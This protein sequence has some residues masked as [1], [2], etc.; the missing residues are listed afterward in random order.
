MVAGKILECSGCG[1]SVLASGSQ[2]TC[3]KCGARLL[4]AR[5][6]VRVERK[7]ASQRRDTCLAC[8]HFGL[9]QIDGNDF[10]G[11]GLLR[12]PCQVELLRLD[13]EWTGPPGR[14]CFIDDE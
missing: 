13:P 11:C 14:I 2:V 4:Y 9:H 5:P 7:V 3:R 12:K 6:K 10:E 1:R 8:E